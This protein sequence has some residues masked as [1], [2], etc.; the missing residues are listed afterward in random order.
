MPVLQAGV[1]LLLFQLLLCDLSPTYKRA[2]SRDCEPFGAQGPVSL[3]KLSAWHIADVQEMLRASS[4]IN[5]EA[6]C[7]TLKG[8]TSVFCKL[9]LGSL[10][11][12]LP[13][14]VAVQ[15]PFRKV[16]DRD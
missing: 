8:S 7:C 13:G 6:G 16:S 3:S 1:T 14:F 12:F 15:K 9:L 5:P 2:S 10:G 4:G 11:C